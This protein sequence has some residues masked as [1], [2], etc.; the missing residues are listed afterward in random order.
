MKSCFTICFPQIYSAHFSVIIDHEKFAFFYPKSFC[1]LE[2]VF[3]L[4]DPHLDHPPSLFHLES[5]LDPLD[6][7]IIPIEPPIILPFADLL[8]NSQRVETSRS[9]DVPEFV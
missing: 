9:C 1:A 8:T 5:A 4:S 6:P 3:C 2:S 7:P